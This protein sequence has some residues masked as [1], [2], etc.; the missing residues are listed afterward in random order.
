MANMAKYMAMRSAVNTTENMRGGRMGHDMDHG[1]MRYEMTDRM[2]DGMESRTRRG[3]VDFDVEDRAP[4]SR[5]RDSRGRFRSESTY[6]PPRS[7]MNTI[8]FATHSGKQGNQ[9]DLHM[10]RG[11]NHGDQFNEE[12]AHEWMDNL[13][14]EDNTQGP[15]WSFGQIKQAAEQRGI[16]ED[17]MRL[18][19]AVNAMYADYCGVAKKYGVDDFDFFL[20]LGKAFLD[21]RDA[22]GDKLAAYFECIVK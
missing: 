11:G 4:E 18:W 12:M 7:E 22:K 2:G 14:R 5:R 15:I 19:V 1:D 21:D 16:K 20:D 3:T 10:M 13:Q 8:G 17:P 9:H 6:Y